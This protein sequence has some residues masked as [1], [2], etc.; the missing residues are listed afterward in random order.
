MKLKV[1]YVLILLLMILP[2]FSSAQDIHF[3]QFYASQL[4]LNPAFAGI[5]GCTRITSAYRD[6]W[7]AIPGNYVTYLFSADHHFS[8][9]NSSGGIILTNDKAGSG[10]LRTT[11]ANLIYA[12][13][14]Q[15]SQRWMARAGLQAG[16]E[17]RN[18]NFYDLIFGDQ[19]A[20]GGAS[21]SLQQPITEGIT[22]PDFSTGAL[23]YSENY[24]IGL[25]AHHLN[26]PNQ[27]LFHEESFIPLKYSL[28]AGAKLYINEPVDSKD[29]GRQFISPAFNYRAQGKYDQADIGFYYNHNVMMLGMWYRGIPLLKAYEKGQPNN[30]AIAFLGGFTVDKFRFGYSYDFTISRLSNRSGGAH[31]IS[32]NYIF[33]QPHKKRKRKLTVPCPKF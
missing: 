30:D 9:I 22:Y 10:N 14:I 24:W 16:L 12:Y 3:T 18:I 17:S 1:K 29:E 33:C 19:I 23:F 21:T 11:A 5:H 26:Q 8:S 4:Y 2:I 13:E 25:S 32:L 7:P 31:E 28:H 6:Q 15:I 20:R 27:S